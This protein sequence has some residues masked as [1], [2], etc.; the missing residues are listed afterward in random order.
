MRSKALV[1]PALME[2]LSA[3]LILHFCRT[4][5]GILTVAL[6]FIVA[7]IAVSGVA[8]LLSDEARSEAVTVTAEAQSEYVQESGESAMAVKTREMLGVP[9]SH[10]QVLLL[11]CASMG[12][13]VLL[14]VALRSEPGQLIR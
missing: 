11:L 8:F 9:D 13:S 5:W 14:A 6:G 7:A 4:K 10:A 1:S 2:A 12:A 3:V